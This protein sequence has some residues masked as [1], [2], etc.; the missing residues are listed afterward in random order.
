M[1]SGHQASRRSKICDILVY[2][3][4]TV[5]QVVL[6]SG[7]GGIG[8]NDEIFIGV[9]GPTLNRLAALPQLILEALSGCQRPIKPI[10]FR[11]GKPL[12]EFDIYGRSVA[13]ELLGK[14]TVVFDEMTS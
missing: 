14:W 7:L 11:A 4:N 2:G 3:S 6:L 10:P 13:P 5:T 8:R 12:C 9:V 1:K